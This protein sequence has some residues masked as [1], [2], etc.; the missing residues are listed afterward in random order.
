M[1]TSESG[2]TFIKNWESF[3]AKAYKDGETSAG[4]TLYSIGYGHQIKKGEESLLSATISKEQALDFVR[5][6][7][8]VWE[9]VVSDR[10]TKNPT[11]AQFDALVSYTYGT[12]VNSTT[13]FSLINKSASAK[14]LFE[15]WTQHWITQTQKGVK[16]PLRGLIRRRWM[17]ADAYLNGF[18]SDSLKGS[19]ANGY[20]APDTDFRPKYDN[21]NITTKPDSQQEDSQDT[22]TNT[23]LAIAAVVGILGI[24]LVLYSY[25]S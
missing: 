22:E 23:A 15:F 25:Q 24:G 7:V 2:I 21:S 13:V 18:N 3:S 9:K 20:N 1:T 17:E 5:K 10:L 8:K 11:Q 19:A 4:K 12:G 14:E 16:V 6:D